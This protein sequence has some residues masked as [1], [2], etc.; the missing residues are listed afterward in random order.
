MWQYGNEKN[1]IRTNHRKWNKFT[2]ITVYVT[3]VLALA[4]V[5]FLIMVQRMVLE[6]FLF[7]KDEQASRNIERVTSIY[8]FKSCREIERKQKRKSQQTR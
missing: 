5:S 7:E 2:E 1:E 6:R 3:I 8:S 4:A